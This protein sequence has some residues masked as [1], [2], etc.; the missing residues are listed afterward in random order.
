[1]DIDNENPENDTYDYIIV[2]A[3]CAGSVLAARLGENPN[4]RVLL[5]EGGHDNMVN[6]EN[7][8]INAYQKKLITSPFMYAGLWARYHVNPMLSDCAQYEASPSHLEFATVKEKSRYYIYPRGNGPGGSTNHH[9][10]VDGRGSHL[11]YERIADMTGDDRWRFENIKK[12]YKKMETFHG[13]NVNTEYHGTTGWL[14]SREIKPENDFTENFIKSVTD[15]GIPYVKDLDIPGQYS[16][17]GH[18]HAQIMPD[19]KRCYAYKD[20]LYPVLQRQNNITVKCNS[21]VAKIIL[22]GNPKLRASGVEV[23]EGKY[24]Y[25]VDTTGNRVV[26]IDGK[27]VAQL[28]DKSVYVKK[29]YMATREVILCGGVFNTPQILMLSGIGPQKHLQELGIETH[30]DRPGVGSNLMDHHEFTMTYALNPARFMWRWQAAYL[31]NEIEKVP[32]N[33]K[34]IVEKYQD[35]S[36]LDEDN[37]HLI[38]D[39]HSGIDEPNPDEPDIHI[40]VV[41]TLFFDFNIN[42]IKIDGDDLN[43][44]ATAKD[45]W[46]PN[47]L[48]PRNS[49]GMPGKGQLFQQQFEPKFPFVFLSFL[50]ENMKIEEPTGSVRLKSRDPRDQ[51][52]IELGLWRQEKTLERLARAVMLVRKIMKTP[53]MMQY[54]VFTSKYGLYEILPSERMDTIEKLKDYLSTWSS[55]GHHASGTARIGRADDPEAVVDS[56]FRLHGVDRLRIVDACVYPA[57]NLHAYN[58]TRG[59]YMI[60]EM[61]ADMIRME[62]YN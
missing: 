57:P 1:M 19:G 2:G 4:I 37:I 26:K 8:E 3:G 48:I 49:V 16:G 43:A 17:L 31:A 54:A 30:L 23:L 50:I 47:P 55:F 45:D 13:T 44:E 39:W 28:P 24:I 51:P 18:N 12:Y 27:C 38:L 5:L 20:L 62:K 35:R 46:I 61:A 25:E 58:P 9:N 29:T 52:V 22:Q 21:V 6:P 34:P 11:P 14:H 7:P 59:I 40:H 15:L 60:A 53:E 41:N 36:A 56:S 42:F 33:L 32:D 10:M